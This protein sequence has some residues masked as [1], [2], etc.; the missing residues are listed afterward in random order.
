[1]D[2]KIKCGLVLIESVIFLWVL[3]VMGGSALPIYQQYDKLNSQQYDMV[4]QYSNE[5]D[6]SDSFYALDGVL[7][8]KKGKGFKA[9][10]LMQKPTQ[11]SS[12]VS[13]DVTD[14]LEKDE[15]VLTENILDSIGKS[16]GDT[17]ELYNPIYD[18][19]VEYRI[20]DKLESIY[21]LYENNVNKQFGVAI[22]GYDKT[23][24]EMT[25][26]KSILFAFDDLKVGETG[27]ALDWSFDKSK[28]LSGLL[29]A[30]IVKA[31][32]IILTILF[33][34]ILFMIAYI[35]FSY[36][37]L[38]KM[39]RIGASQQIINRYVSNNYLMPN[40]LAVLMSIILWEL[41]DWFL[42]GKI[43]IGAMIILFPCLIAVFV[44]QIIIKSF[45]RRRN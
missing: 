34:I 36:S 21:G 42:E 39:Y 6:I 41:I 43:Y 37:R 18:S 19:Y 2:K 20:A 1:M 30:L 24:P 3:F 4:Y 26:L 29:Y 28:V 23:I 35:G 16:V 31:I 11:Y 27:M 38:A 32:I 7:T 17:I 14:S 22:F 45:V 8:Y 13:F 44:G 25:K 9:E 40:V 15:I 5:M 33:L 10:M 12:V